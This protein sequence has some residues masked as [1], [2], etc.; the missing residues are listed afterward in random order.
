[1]AR[2]VLAMDAS[3]LDLLDSRY[4]SL[5]HFLPLLRR[6]S[7]PGGHF[8]FLAERLEIT[9]PD[10]ELPGTS[11]KVTTDDPPAT[12][13]IWP[14]RAMTLDANTAQVV[15]ASVFHFF[16]TF[17]GNLARAPLRHED[18]DEQTGRNWCPS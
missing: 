8:F 5:A 7:L 12:Q 6:E 13:A 11:A 10:I 14:R 17:F 18:C 9:A 15:A 3:E 1:L 4:N 16:L 2:A